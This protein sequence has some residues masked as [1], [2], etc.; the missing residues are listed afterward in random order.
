MVL[1]LDGREFKTQSGASYYYLTD[2]NIV[3]SKEALDKFPERLNRFKRLPGFIK[4]TDYHDIFNDYSPEDVRL[5]ILK[6][7]LF[8]L[9]IEVTSMC[10]FRCKYCV[11]S[12]IYRNQRNHD[13]I[14]MEE[15]VAFKAIDSYLLLLKQGKV[16]NSDRTPVVSFYGG[17]P[18]INFELIRKCVEYIKSKYDGHVQYSI[19]TNGSLLTD[20]TIDF[21]VA[22][23]FS[24][25]LSID[26][27]KE[28]HDRNRRDMFDNPT[29]DKVIKN[30]KKL[31]QKQGAPVF[32]NI[33]FDY[34]TDFTRLDKFFR[35]NNFLIC[36]SVNSVN[37]YNTTY[38]DKYTRED[39]DKFDMQIKS[40][41]NNFKKA[42]I[43]NEI[44]SLSFLSR[45][46]GDIC[47]SS[48]TRQCDLST[49]NTKMI[50]R[51]GSCVPGNKIFV[52][53]KG[54]FYICEK[55]SRNLKIGDVQTG[56]DFE[57]CAN[58]VNRFNEVTRRQC[59]QCVIRNNCKRCY[60]SMK[61]DDK[62]I[63]IFTE[64]CKKQISDF[65]SNLSFA[66]TIFE[67]NSKW[68]G[69]YF[70]D[71]YDSIGEMMRG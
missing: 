31:F 38:F 18:L 2:F 53:Y 10:N 55:V 22:E 1:D 5:E 21:L 51:T 68:I 56:L 50:K 57:K 47:T 43:R 67:L 44:N 7:G 59:Q 52:D 60:T 63:S 6:N 23:G 3:L 34:D 24:V 64:D 37:P 62:E 65:F 8:E 20:Q 11:Y 40:L 45:V 28:N 15:T 17:E 69:R 70:N 4:G 48:F 58:I 35:E 27:Y 41:S 71:Y 16:Y 29:F 25:V 33:V 66:Y 46:F 32:V 42:V 19:T 61:I 36:L 49:K 12:G 30:A 9:A 26:G 54:N 13:N 14:N 39:Y